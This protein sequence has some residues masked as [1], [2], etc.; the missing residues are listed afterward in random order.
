MDTKVTMIYD[1]PTDPE[2]FEA[3]YPEQLASEI[4][5]GWA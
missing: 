3:G 2:A 5:T 1:N 4:D